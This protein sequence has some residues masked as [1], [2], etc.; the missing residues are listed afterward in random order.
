MFFSTKWRRVVVTL[1][2]LV[3]FF[4]W[5]IPSASAAPYNSGTKT[6]DVSCTGGGYFSVTSGVLTGN[7]GCA[8]IAAIPDGVTSIANA[9]FAGATSLTTLS[10]PSSVTSIGQE[11]FAG[12]TSLTTLSIPGSV[13]T[14]GIQAFYG[15]T[16][17]TTLSFL[18]IPSSVTSIG[19]EAF[20]GASS[21]TTLSIPSS[22]T[23]IGHYAFYGASSLTTLSIPSS[24]TSIGEGV[25]YGATSLTT[26]SIPSSVTSIGPGAFYGATS[27]TTLSIPSSVTSI[28]ENAFSGRSTVFSSASSYDGRFTVQVTNYDAAFTYTAT[29]SAGQASINSFGLITVTGLSPNQ[30]VAVTMTTSR[31]GFETTTA[32]VTGRSQVAAMTPSDK[33]TVTLSDTLITCTIGS[34]SQTPTSSAFSLFVDGKHI[35]TNFSALGDYLPDWI[36]PWATSSTI[37]RTAS[38][39]S[40]TWAMSDAYKGKAIT[41][42]TLAYSK[43]AIGFTASQVIVAR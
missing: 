34:Y 23:S 8:G 10:I 1:S 43:N 9:A 12:A 5:G 3:S 22:V 21:L 27:L 32:S 20:S 13:T 4:V 19:D 29:S 41:C 30:S 25:F 37:T 40:A 36:I 6:G 39:T 24:I 26:L 16:S 11:A 7:N 38:L 31:S 33:P 14:I 2:L 35:S 17:L 18:S 28:G 15:A 42:S